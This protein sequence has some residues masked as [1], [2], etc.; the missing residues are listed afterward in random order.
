MEKKGLVESSH[1]MARPDAAPGRPNG[2][3]V[4]TAAERRA[5]LQRVLR[6]QPIE[7]SERVREFLAYVCER[8]LED[9]AA[10]IHEQE[11]GCKVF[12]RD[13]DYDTALDNVVRGDRLAGSQATRAV[14]RGRTG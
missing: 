13:E 10:E 11:I 8:A 12:G 4:A 1:A 6:S 14:F 9:P 7:K 5:L 3:G 2:E